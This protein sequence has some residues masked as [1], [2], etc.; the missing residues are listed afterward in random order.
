MLSRLCWHPSGFLSSKLQAIRDPL[1]G[2]MKYLKFMGYKWDINGNHMGVIM[3][4]GYYHG[5]ITVR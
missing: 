5:Y 4:I 1:N 2:T 3:A